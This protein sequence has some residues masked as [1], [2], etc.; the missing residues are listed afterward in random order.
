MRWWLVLAVFAGGYLVGWYVSRQ[1]DAVAGI[2]NWMLGAPESSTL[3]IGLLVVAVL[4]VATRRKGLKRAVAFRWVPAGTVAELIQAW[5]PDGCQ[6]HKDYQKSLCAFLAEALADVKVT[7]ESGSSRVRADIEVGKAVIVEL[8]VGF[9]ST[10]KLQQLLGQ[11]ELYKREF[12]GQAI[13]TVFIG[14]T[15]RNI[16]QNFREALARD[17][18]VWVIRK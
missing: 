18:K 7:M 3:L 9:D 6:S 10:A 1:L 5:Q 16:F 13:I 8:K 15:D 11:I 17:A 14:K 12:P 2:S 4:G